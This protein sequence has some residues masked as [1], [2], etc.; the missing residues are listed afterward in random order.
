MVDNNLRFGIVAQI[1]VPRDEETLQNEC[2]Q[3]GSLSLEK[4][5]QQKHGNYTEINSGTQSVNIEAVL[6]C[7]CSRAWDTVQEETVM[8]TKRDANA[9]NQ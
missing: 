7:L 8:T 5:L 1:T 3:N 4:T 2:H 9:G 6:F